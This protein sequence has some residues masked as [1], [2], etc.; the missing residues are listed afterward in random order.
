MEHEMALINRGSKMT[1]GSRLAVGE[2]L[3]SPNRVY[4]FVYQPDGNLVLYSI[5][6]GSRGTPRWASDTQGKPPGV[7]RFQPDGKLVMLSSDGSQIWEATLKARPG[8][9]PYL[10]LQDDGNLV[11]YSGNSEPYWATDTWEEDVPRSALLIGVE[12][13]PAYPGKELL[14]GRNDVLAFWQVCR[15]LGYKPE[16]IRVRTSPRLTK[17]QILAAEVDLALTDVEN[18]NKSR[19]EVAEDVRAKLDRVPWGEEGAPD[20]M[21][22]AVIGEATHAALLAAV[23][24][25]GG[26]LG[27]PFRQKSGYM[28]PAIL[29][30]SG[31]GTQ[32]E[33]DFALCATDVA[34]EGT[35]TKN[36]LTAT[37]IHRILCADDKEPLA[38]RNPLKY[39]T[40]VL[41]C[42]FAGAASGKAS[43]L[44][45]ESRRSTSLATSETSWA[46]PLFDG[47]LGQR[48]FC[49]SR[50]DEQAY[51]ALLGGRWHG[52]FTWA[53]T[54]ALEQW[55]VASSGLHEHIDVSHVELLYR[56]RTLL[57]ALSFPQHPMLLDSVGNSPVFWSGA[58]RFETDEY[59]SD[60]EQLIAPVP[61][62]AP[63]PDRPRSVIQIDPGG[64]NKTFHEVVLRYGD[65]AVATIILPSSLA[66]GTAWSEDT[67]Y[68][69]VDR[70]F[71]T[72][73]GESGWTLSIAGTDDPGRDPSKSLQIRRATQWNR[74]TT[75]GVNLACTNAGTFLFGLSANGAPGSATAGTGPSVFARW[76]NGIAQNIQLRDGTT[77]VLSRPGALKD[78]LYSAT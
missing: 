44:V 23:R 35:G 60:L 17:E 51:Q 2:M 50:H 78:P 14:A 56:A 33:G 28:I 66:A 52:A 9:D 34:P 64:G 75:N 77:Y 21:C 18:R 49:A 57:E 1:P 24:W 76:F 32:I 29:A 36:V 48:V 12:H 5:S 37:E 65:L 43:A 42:C 47:K 68:W 69:F 4:A 19:E 40:V 31:H 7:V 62:T 59:S 63:E 54:Q 38:G 46:P 6:D 10:V 67:E 15:R 71:D 25:L 22:E 27:E 30:Y 70:T 58:E 20:P 41:D 72:S 55:K 73:N 39:L 11:G 74:D 8:P 13:Y 26:R 3:V 53:V 61:Q 16:N 45:Q